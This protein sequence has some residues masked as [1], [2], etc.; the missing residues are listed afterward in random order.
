MSC[1]QGVGGGKS[2]MEK[3]VILKGPSTDTVK[4]DLMTECLRILFPGCEI[5]VSVASAGD[6]PL[7]HSESPMQR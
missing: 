2:R 1:A 6:G 4:E 5:Q 7:T 3:I